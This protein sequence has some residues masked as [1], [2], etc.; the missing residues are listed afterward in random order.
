MPETPLGTP[1]TWRHTWRCSAEPSLD[2]RLRPD[3]N[4]VGEWTA[5]AGDPQTSDLVGKFGL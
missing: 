3:Q 1:G 5:R 2:F 4:L